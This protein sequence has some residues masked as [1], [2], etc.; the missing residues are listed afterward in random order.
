[1]VTLVGEREDPDGLFVGFRVLGACEVGDCD[2]GEVGARVGSCVGLLVAFVGTAVVGSGVLGR[3]VRELG[4]NVSVGE[5][6]ELMS[7]GAAVVGEREV[8][9]EE[10]GERVEGLRVTGL[11]LVGVN[12]GVSVGAR[13]GR[14][15]GMSVG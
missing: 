9:D 13:L 11:L 3:E 7:V 15:V 5:E 10:E 14:R 2:V 8:G 1:M 4:A 6:V 12:V